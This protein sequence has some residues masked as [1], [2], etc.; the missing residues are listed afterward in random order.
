MILVETNGSWNFKGHFPNFTI[1]A[2]ILTATSS[3]IGNIKTITMITIAKAKL[4]TSA[5]NNT[6]DPPNRSS[7]D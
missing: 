2:D 5:F 7:D 4:K 3:L 6:I 1:T